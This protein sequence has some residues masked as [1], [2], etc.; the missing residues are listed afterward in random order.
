MG[1]G[2]LGGDDASAVGSDGAVGRHG[3][4]RG[5][6]VGGDGIATECGTRE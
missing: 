4:K 5:S 1:T 3:E 2:P 6:D